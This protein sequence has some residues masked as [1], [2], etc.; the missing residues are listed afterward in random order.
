MPA[1]GL[2]PCIIYAR[3][4]KT[5]LHYWDSLGHH[6]MEHAVRLRGIKAERWLEHKFF[7]TLVLGHAKNVKSNANVCSCLFEQAV[8]GCV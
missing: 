1:D 3:S 7:Q 8:N 4:K 2:E 6:S 5:G